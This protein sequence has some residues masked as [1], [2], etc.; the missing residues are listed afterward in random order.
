M[1]KNYFVF[2]DSFVNNG[3]DNVNAIDDDL[4]QS[5]DEQPIFHHA[6]NF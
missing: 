4:V 1:N 2:V 5:Q 6:L 3:P